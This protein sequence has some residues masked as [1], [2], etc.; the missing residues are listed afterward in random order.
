MEN[1]SPFPKVF[2]N[3]SLGEAMS[4]AR[5]SDYMIISG[6]TFGSWCWG[7]VFGKPVRGPAAAMAGTLG[8]TAGVLLAYQNSTGRLM[9]WKENQKEISR[10]GTTA[11]REAAEAQK[12]LDEMSAAMKAA[13]EE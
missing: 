2:D 6:T 10:W 9:G 12:K 4:G 13:R 11:E 7:Y 3:P 5:I 1:K 8:L